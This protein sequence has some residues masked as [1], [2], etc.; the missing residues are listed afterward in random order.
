MPI[1]LPTD[2][3]LKA[4]PV[5]R[6]GKWFDK[7]NVDELA[8]R[9]LETI[10]KNSSRITE[11]QTALLAPIPV[12]DF[13]RMEAQYLTL[14]KNQY[15]VNSLLAEAEA[16]LDKAQAA[17]LLPCGTSAICRDKETNEPIPATGCKV[18]DP[19]HADFMPRYKELTDN[20]RKTE[21]DSLVAPFRRFRDEMKAL[22][23]G[24]NNRLFNIKGY[25][26]DIGH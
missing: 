6:I 11:T 16:L 22:A 9:L 1:Q 14:D 19:E 23:E 12:S 15:L 26:R 24:V 8:N 4:Y 5:M 17:A 18:K 13:A 2:D 7:P 20:D 3:E 25:R 21:Q 10:R